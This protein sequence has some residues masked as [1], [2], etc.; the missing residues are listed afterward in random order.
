[1]A[2]YLDLPAEL[3]SLIEKREREDRR[4]AERRSEDGLAQ[5]DDPGAERRTS[6]RRGEAPRRE[7]ED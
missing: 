6:E 4:V 7:G 3:Q 2:N 1:M 5:D